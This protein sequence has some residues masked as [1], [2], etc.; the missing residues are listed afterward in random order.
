MALRWIALLALLVLGMISISGCQSGGPTQQ[1]LEQSQ[2][3]IE[4]ANKKSG[5]QQDPI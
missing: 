5:A 1:S 4:E 2:K 3:E